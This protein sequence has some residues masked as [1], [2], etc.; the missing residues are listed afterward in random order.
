[1]ATAVKKPLPP[2]PPP[3]QDQ[4]AAPDSHNQTNRRP[5]DRQ[6]Q[7]PDGQ[8]S[9]QTY[10][11]QKLGFVGSIMYGGSKVIDS[12]W[13]GAAKFISA[14]K[15]LDPARAMIAVLA[16]TMI[17]GAIGATTAVG[18]MGY[19]SYSVTSKGNG[20]NN[21]TSAALIKLFN[22]ADDK[23]SVERE[24]DSE[25][26]L[27]ENERN[28]VEQ[29]KNREQIGRLSDKIEQVAAAN[30]RIVKTNE[31]IAFV[32]ERLSGK[33]PDPMA[34]T[35]RGKGDDGDLGLVIPK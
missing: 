9:S 30:E 2:S 32:L 1:M 23:R 7:D 28:R 21:D 34:P 25:Q 33:L 12:G 22:E 8:Q 27:R 10:P 4:N 31:K 24:R 15:G 20:S 13:G 14:F 17:M 11:P 6:Y 3:A 29:E 18:V 35:P 5:P 16:V 19:I 26:R